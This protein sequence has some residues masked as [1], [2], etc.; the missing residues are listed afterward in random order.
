[1]KWGSANAKAYIDN[2]VASNF[3]Y[4]LT[5]PND[6]TKT[7]IRTSAT[8]ISEKQT[9]LLPLTHNPSSLTQETL[10]AELPSV[11]RPMLFHY[12]NY[13]YVIGGNVSS[14]ST[15]AIRRYNLETRQLEI[16]DITFPVKIARSM[17]I[18]I[19]D[20]AYFIGGYLL[21]GGNATSYNSIWKMDLKTLT[22]TQEFTN[23][24]IIAETYN[25][26]KLDNKRIAFVKPLTKN[27]YIY[28]VE[29]QSFEISTTKTTQDGVDFAC[30]NKY[31]KFTVYGYN[32]LYSCV[33][34][35]SL[36]SNPM[37]QTFRTYLYNGQAIN[38]RYSQGVF[39]IENNVYSAG[40]VRG[41]SY[42]KAIERL[43]MFEDQASAFDLSTNE[44]PYG[45][46]VTGA[47]V[48]E[49]TAVVCC[50][51]TLILFKDEFALNEN[52][53]ILETDEYGNVINC[54]I[55]NSSNKAELFR[56]YKYNA[57]TEKWEGVNCQ[58]YNA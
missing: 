19:G 18:V 23:S 8:P 3:Y 35:F 9:Y 32:F 44:L 47:N 50:W 49:N 55:G 45:T 53:S 51:D 10:T 2:S 34:S 58:D 40:G 22:I 54:Y 29:T 42:I 24:N 31:G 48:N 21:T 16:L 5:P 20:N 41:N 1:M 52:E 36:S 6:T 39:C 37:G 43:N 13:I 4:G 11:G 57:L 30:Q 17:P 38:P 27:T 14:E 56:V 26:F 7:W 15:N 46:D 25:A 12:K 28:N 33:N